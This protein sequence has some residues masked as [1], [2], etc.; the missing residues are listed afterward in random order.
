[1]AEHYFVKE[2]EVGIST[3]PKN[4]PPQVVFVDTPGLSA[5]ESD[6]VVAYDAY[7][8]ANMIIFVHNI[9]VGELHEN[10]LNAI[11]KIKNLFNNDEFFCKH[12]CVAF[13][14]KESDSEENINLI[15]EKSLN[16]IKNHCGISEFKNFLVSNSD[17]QKGFA[18]DK[19]LLVKESGITELRNYLTKSFDEWNNE[20][21][22]FRGMRISNEKKIFLDALKIE[23]DKIN[24]TIKNKTAELK[25]N[26]KKFLHKVESVVNQRRNDEKDLEYHRSQLYSLKNNLENTR[27]RWNNERF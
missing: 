24:S 26:Q 9:Q 20:N 8:R 7:K 11:N 2:I 16:D 1:M 6:D 18:E 22:Y 25:N 19:K 15:V 13:T 17:Y 12:F 27:T 3:L 23:R 4:F 5:E 21:K 14:F 10:E